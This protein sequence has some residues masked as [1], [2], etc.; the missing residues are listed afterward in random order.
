MSAPFEAGAQFPDLALQDTE[1]RSTRLGEAMGGEPA[2]VY[3]LRSASCAVCRNHL[4]S[5]AKKH[6]DIK[7]SGAQV[8]A[9]VPDGLDAAKE[10]ATWLSLPVRVFTNTTHSHAEAG[11]EPVLFG[12][13]QPSGTLLLGKT[14]HVHYARR[15]SFPPLS[16]NERELMEAL[17]KGAHRT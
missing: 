13:L 14:R 15:A 9:V 10:L 16:Y 5:I 6:S 17:A 2:V 12:K 7:N 1:G 3:F 8:L 4:K 11:L